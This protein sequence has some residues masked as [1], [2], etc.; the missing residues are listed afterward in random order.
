M[1]FSIEG[2]NLGLHSIV[3]P[4]LLV[5]SVNEIFEEDCYPNPRMMEVLVVENHV[6]I[7]NLLHK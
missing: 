4:N 5:N 1:R 6:F 7:E 2:T 3:L